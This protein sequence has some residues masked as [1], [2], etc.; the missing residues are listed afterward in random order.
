MGFASD[1][2]TELYYYCP[3]GLPDLVSTAIVRMYTPAGF[4]IAADGRVCD[5]NNVV[6]SDAT[7]KIFAIENDQRV[8][9]Y[10]FTGSAKLTPEDSDEIVFDFV[11]EAAKVVQDLATRK[12]KNLYGYAVRLSVAIN[13]LLSDGKK[14]GRIPTFPTQGRP[15]PDERGVSICRI[16]LD[17]YYNGLASRVQI[18][19][20]HEDQKVAEPMI[21]T[22]K[23]Q[24]WDS[25]TVGSQFVRE[26]LLDRSDKTFEA[27]RVTPEQFP[28][29]LSYAVATARSHIQ[30]HGDP[31]ALAL[32]AEVCRGIG[33][34][35]HIATVTPDRGFQWVEGFEPLDPN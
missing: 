6:I 23:I 14:T 20:G 15:E 2:G 29:A 4:V 16:F 22:D 24:A 32:D 17:G 1:L 8:L 11:A 33:G 35:I 30:A 13:A 28:D 21:F 19:F 26:L 9:A 3:G 31:A 10:S 7:Q 34:H 18:R 12:S 5:D 25:R 27:Y